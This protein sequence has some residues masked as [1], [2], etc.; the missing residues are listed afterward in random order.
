MKDEEPNKI[1][2]TLFTITVFL[3]SLVS[4]IYVHEVG[5]WSMSKL[6]GMDAKIFMFNCMNKGD[7]LNSGSVFTGH[8]CVE[9]ETQSWKNATPIE[10]IQVSVGGFLPAIIGIITAIIFFV[11]INNLT[12]DIY[13]G[14]F[15]VL[16]SVFFILMGISV[17]IPGTSDFGLIERGLS[18]L[19]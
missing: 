6:N 14:I 19:L 5:H 12:I 3:F 16:F 17:F 15:L 7:P 11:K 1:L 9:P 2:I 10:R 8:S 4:S 13:S 18:V